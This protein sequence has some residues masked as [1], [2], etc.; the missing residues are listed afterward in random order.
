MRSAAIFSAIDLM[1]CVSHAHAASI[2]LCGRLDPL[3]KIEGTDVHDLHLDFVNLCDPR[4]VP[5]PGAGSAATPAP[6]VSQ[7][8]SVV[9]K[10][11][12][13]NRMPHQAADAIGTIA[14]VTWRVE[15]QLQSINREIWETADHTGAYYIVRYSWAPAPA[16]LPVDRVKPRTASAE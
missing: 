16:L 14:G 1:L 11:A 8:C 2:V 6:N 10:Q 12:L 9:G 4:A 15:G 5:A 7:Y 3:C 13:D